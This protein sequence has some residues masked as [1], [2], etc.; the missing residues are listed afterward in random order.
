[1]PYLGDHGG[2]QLRRDRHRSKLGGVQIVHGQS[3]GQV[4][5]TGGF[6]EQLLELKIFIVEIDF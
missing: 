1:M 6:L 3:H 2:S 5:E 4:T